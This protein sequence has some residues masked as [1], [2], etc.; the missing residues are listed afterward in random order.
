MGFSIVPHAWLPEKVTTDCSSCVQFR[1]CGQYAVIHTLRRARHAC[2][3]LTA[4]HG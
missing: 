3:P 2:V 1:Q 4:L